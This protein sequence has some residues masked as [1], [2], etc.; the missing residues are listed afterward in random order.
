[1]SALQATIENTYNTGASIG[2]VDEYHIQSINQPELI[3]DDWQKLEQQG[4]GCI[5]QNYDWVRIACNT[6]EK[7]N[8]P[9]IITARNKDGLQFVLPMVIE[10]KTFKKLRWAG[11]THANICGGLYAEA[12]L[13][14]IDPQT[15]QEIFKLIKKSISGIAQSELK[16]QP[17]KL[18]GYINPMTYLSQGASVNNM[19]DMDLRD[20]ID[21]ILDAGSGKRKRKL[22]RK[23]NRVA[24]SMGG[25]ELF[26]PSSEEEISESLKTFF[27]LKAIRFHEMG[28]KNVFEAKDTQDFFLEMALMPKANGVKLFEIYELR[29]G[30]KTRAM[31]AAGIYGNYCQAYVNAV[32]YDEFAEHSPGEMVLYAMIEHLIAEGYNK[33]DLGVGDERYKRSWCPNIHELFDTTLPLSKSAIPFVHAGN[34]KNSAKRYIRNNP[35]I[36]LKVKKIRKLKALF[37]SPK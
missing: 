9:Y 35:D 28:I 20:G 27:D 24:E 26:I 1:M 3:K 36:W 30:G 15:M 21:V 25:C 5:Y 37:I 34:L 4:M 12:F 13:K 10:G 22:W 8:S 6:I 19:Y 29:I 23:Q 17:L 33:L 2:Y 31:Y 7:N 14:L 11:N 18:H 32:A 16:N